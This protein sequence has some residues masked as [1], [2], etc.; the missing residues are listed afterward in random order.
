MGVQRDR[1]ACLWGK[2]PFLCP[3]TLQCRGAQS[4]GSKLM[5]LMKLVTPCSSAALYVTF[6]L[7][8]RLPLEQAYE[9]VLASLSLG[10]A[11]METRFPDD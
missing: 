6:P 5:T 2:V 4:G 8:H 9:L 1:T 10:T 3:L 11:G 7:A